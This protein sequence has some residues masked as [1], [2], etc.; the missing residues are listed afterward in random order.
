M[1]YMICYDIS[2]PKRLQK[3]AKILENLGIRIQKSF[4]QCEIEDKKKEVLVSQVLKVIKPKK[5]YFYVY[6]LCEDC[7]QKAIQDGTGSLIRLEPF[8]IL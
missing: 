4:F 7:S 8:D 2:D 5:D 1:I 6:P 3:T